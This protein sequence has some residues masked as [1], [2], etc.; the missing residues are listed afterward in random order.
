MANGIVQLPVTLD[1]G[2]LRCLQEPAFIACLGEAADRGKSER[3]EQNDQRDAK[4]RIDMLDNEVW[5]EAFTH[6]PSLRQP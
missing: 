4:N 5:N 2:V 1:G 6:S 3:K